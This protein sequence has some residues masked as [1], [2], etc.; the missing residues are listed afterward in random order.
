MAARQLRCRQCGRVYAVAPAY[1]CADCLGPLE[2]VLEELPDAERIRAGIAGGPRT[3]WRYVSLLPVG[4]DPVADLGAG[5]TPLVQARNLGGVL[6]LHR[7]YLK[8]DGCNP[9]W[10][11]KD[12]VVALG[13]AAARRFGFTVLACASTGNLAN[14]VAAH[15][16]R[17]AMPAVVFVPAGLEAG[18]Q[19]LSA[20]YG[21]VI[22]EVSGTYDDVN[23]LCAQVAD[24]HPWAS[25]SGRTTAKARRR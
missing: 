14:S 3:L 17:A 24:E 25:T 10:S 18:K 13:T 7:L 11:F 12:R 15:A 9:T 6:G 1:V 4:Y 20:A 16:A 2:A 22:V 23:R 19:V 5:M 8:N 21:A